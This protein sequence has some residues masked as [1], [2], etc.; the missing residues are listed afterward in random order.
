[1]TDLE[2]LVVCFSY[3]C[4]PDAKLKE[5]LIEL[6]VQIK[7]TVTK[8]VTHFITTADDL[9]TS[10]TKLIQTAKS[11]EEVKKVT[12]GFLEDCVKEKKVVDETKFLVPLLSIPEEDKP[13]LRRGQRRKVSSEENIEADKSEN[14]ANDIEEEGVQQSKRKK[15]KADKKK[16]AETTDI[17]NDVGDEMEIEEEEVSSKEKNK[18]KVEEK[19]E[20]KMV[21]QIMRK[22]KAPVDHIAAIRVG[23]A[24][25][26]SDDHSIY[27][28]ML[29]QTEID[30]NNN[31]FYII[32]VLKSD[33]A[34]KYY[35]WTRW[36]R[37]G[38]NGQNKL[39]VFDNS[40]QSISAFERKFKDKTKNSWENRENF[41]KVKGKYFLIER[42]KIFI[43]QL[44]D[45]IVVDY[46]DDN[47]EE[48]P[49]NQ[50]K[51]EETKIPDSKLD[52]KI[53]NLMKMIFNVDLMKEAMVEVGYDANKMPLG[54][55]S[56]DTI[57]KGYSTLKEISEELNKGVTNSHTIKELSSKFYTI[58]PH[59]FG[60]S[61]PPPINTVQLLKSKLEMLEA[62]GEMKTSMDLIKDI[63][64]SGGEMVN[65]LDLKYSSLKCFLKPVP[66]DDKIYKIILDYVKHSH[67]ETHDAY[68]LVV[69]EVFDMK[70]DGEDERFLKLQN[71]KLLWHGS[72]L[73]NYCGIISQGLRIAPP[74]A[75]VTGYMFGKGVY[76]AD[77]VSKSANYCFTNKKNN[78]GLMLLCE[79]SLGDEYL[80]R[81]S[82]YYA[83]KNSKKHHKNSTKGC[84]ATFPDPEGD[85][86]LD[87][88]LT[89][90][91]GPTKKDLTPG[92]ALLYNEYIV[93][94][95]SQIRMR[96]LIKMKFEYK[97]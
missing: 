59:A 71:R 25:V 5:D 42:G 24:H 69:E 80:L 30:K 45:E 14:Y 88:G 79:V 4:K 22:G 75:P 81:Q 51:T 86:L 40:Q 54:K 9:N 3:A 31:K 16:K 35:C 41:E 87:D 12:S 18:A 73:T 28:A 93:Y 65:P 58:I 48:D 56:K 83:D 11:R 1:M 66:K 96:Y 43:E 19:K 6:G 90:P 37:V 64:D 2:H 23:N 84:G 72:R 89:V 76:F 7:S 97:Y 21:K 94:D 8:L 15:Q 60:M 32:Q 46:S 95:V 39:E 47:V 10:H 53:Q 68:N 78:E 85:I 55:L 26:Y 61:R 91:F 27:D 50:K 62:L 57:L 49:N 33:D 20:P 44:S 92:G 17:N 13:V 74:E 70:R 63:S 29:N 34:E 67:A 38:V 82:D 36:G 52:V 77:M